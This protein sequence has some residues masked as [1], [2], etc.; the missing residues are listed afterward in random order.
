MVHNIQLKSSILAKKVDIYKKIDL[1]GDEF[2][3]I[4]MDLKKKLG[5][6]V[7]LPKRA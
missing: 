6:D 5:I 4:Y 1:L 3:I 7:E 2:R